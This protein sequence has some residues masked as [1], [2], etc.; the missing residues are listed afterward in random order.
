MAEAD[1]GT[2]SPPPPDRP[3]PPARPV[4]PDR[5]VRV[6]AHRGG[7]GLVGNAGIENTIAAFARAVT[8]GFDLETDV[9]ASSDGVAVLHHDPDLA[10]TVGDPRPIAAVAWRELQRLLVGGREPVA[11]LDDLLEAHPGVAVNI[12]VK[13]FAAIGATV[14]AVRRT[15]H[16]GRLTL[17]SFS[18]VRAG[19]VRRALGDAVSWSATPVEIAALVAA[20][21]LRSGRVRSGRLLARALRGPVGGAV[22]GVGAI[23][24]PISLATGRDGPGLI[25]L[26]HGLGIEV[27]VWTVDDAPLARVLVGSG[28]DGLISDRP[29]VVAAC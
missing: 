18:P 7:P 9:R 5:P 19:L 27:H 21:R 24:I 26:A 14:D 11:R 6:I 25:A 28:V 17:A 12:D 29:D 8:A 3:V 13:D 2:G 23:Q 15:R 22:R 1:T 4:P 16:P 20:G 10:R